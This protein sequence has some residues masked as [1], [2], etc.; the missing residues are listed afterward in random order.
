MEEEK[1]KRDEITFSQ[2]FLDKYSPQAKGNKG[3][4]SYRREQDLFTLWIS[5][6]IGNVPQPAGAT[7]F[8]PLRSVAANSSGCD[9]NL[10]WGGRQTS[11][12]VIV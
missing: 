9:Y 12:T 1:R 7:S 2:L 6:V 5:P 11:D 4:Q 10:V 3:V 8:Y